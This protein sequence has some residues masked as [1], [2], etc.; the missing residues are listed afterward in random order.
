MK[1]KR[2]TE[3]IREQVNDRIRER[4]VIDNTLVDLRMELILTLDKDRRAELEARQQEYEQKLRENTSQLERLETEYLQAA[5]TEQQV[6]EAL[7]AAAPERSNKELLRKYL[8]WVYEQCSYVSLAGIDRKA[9]GRRGDARL[10]LD[11]I[12]TALLTTASAPE[13]GPKDRRGESDFA[14]EREGKRLSAVAQLNAHDRLVLLGDPGSGKSTFVNFAA[15]CLAGEQLQRSSTDQYAA[16]QDLTAPLP[17]EEEEDAGPTPQPW[18]H[19]A[20]TPV[21]VILRDFAAWRGLP[22]ADQPVTEEHFW[23]FLT[24]QLRNAAREECLPAVQA[25]LTRQGGL[26]LFDGLDEVSE[27]EQRREQIIRLV[28]RC[29]AAFRRCRIVVTSRTYAYQEQQWRL[30]KFQT[31]ELA[32]FT[33]AQIQ[34]FITRW[35]EHV[36][37]LRRL[38]RKKTED[39]IRRLQ[40]AIDNSERLRSFAERPLLLALMT[41][42]HAWRGGSLPEKREE[43]YDDAVE[44]LLDWWESQK[45]SAKRSG[46]GADEAPSLSALLDVN[47]DRLRQVLSAL[48]FEAHARQPEL[49]GTADIA[50]KD[51]VSGLMQVSPKRD[52]NPVRLVEYLSNRAGLLV[53]RGVGVYTFP[54]RTFQEYL[55]ACRL[56]DQ[57]DYPDNIAALA[58]AAPNR[59]R[60]VLLLA[61][62]HASNVAPMIWALTDAL[63]FQEPS[64]NAD[65][66]DAWGALLAAQ[67]LLESADLSRISPRNAVRLERVR[68]WLAAIL[69]EQAPADAPFPVVE[70]ALAGRLLA[71]LGDPR[72]GVGLRDDGLPD[73][74]W[75]EVPA[76]TFLMGSDK[77]K[78]PQAYDREM[79]QH[80]VTVPGFKMSRYPIT[81]AQYQAFVDDGGKEPEKYRDPF[82]LPNHPVVG[83]TWDDAMAFCDWL[84]ARLLA[85][86]DV[87]EGMV[88][89]LPSE[90]EWE[91]AAR[92]PEGRMY[93]WGDEITPEHAN[94]DENL[95]AT[96]A[97]GCF[98]RGA[99]RFSGCEEMAG[100]VWE[101]CLDDWHDSY[102]GAPG[103]GSAWIDNDKRSSEKLLRGGSW[104]SIPRL[105]RCACRRRNFLTSGNH[106]RGFR[107]VCGGRWRTL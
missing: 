35:Y 103:D 88:V 29:S 105:C 15:L 52:V 14:A 42:L 85:A 19:G 55:A 7:P 82:G 87:Q 73:I 9:A 93:P 17:Q 22:P 49:A 56:T 10:N 89:R 5:E 86:G 34:A 8:E 101:W 24:D 97:V 72:P 75:R 100:N 58:K 28:E 67:A 18:D 31:A 65:G 3:E 64:E 95:G 38:G 2:K 50:E 102:E 91:Y 71:Q 48:A 62:A 21:R 23:E 32:R 92:G 80:E 61:A 16:L 27:A 37:K 43:L 106:V 45:F 96:S 63:C 78:D 33:N 99:S 77:S 76:G 20:L 11:D 54:H 25:E 90:A 30:E 68:T 53:P 47:K 59:W 79:P 74:E 69:T 41:S 12:Y 1:R 26:L 46:S 107:V 84:T 104:G 36:G 44:L 40:Y 81:N 6:F 94:Y 4:A 98:P 57:D 83:V 60:E 51:L 66:P 13:Q 39:S 70:R